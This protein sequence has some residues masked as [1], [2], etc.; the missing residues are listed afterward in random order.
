MTDKH[1]VI[2]IDGLVASGKSTVS[3][4]LAQKLY[5][6]HVNSGAL[7]RNVAFWAEKQKVSLKDENQLEKIAQ[8]LKFEFKLNSA[9][10]TELYVNNMPCSQEI[11][12]EHIGLLASQVSMFPKVR[13]VATEVQRAQLLNGSLVLEGRDAGSIVF[14]N[15]KFKFYLTASVEVRAE[16]RLKDQL[17]QGNPNVNLEEIKENLERRDYTDTH[18]GIYSLKI[19]ETTQIIKTDD[20]DIDEIVELLAVKVKA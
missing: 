20:L 14:P 17:A 11:F 6:L 12:N 19:T 3:R 4:K 5:F 8:S 9:G 10:I 1:I 16:R 7:Y 13:T 2:T 15:A 18:K